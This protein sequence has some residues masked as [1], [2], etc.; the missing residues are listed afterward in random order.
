MSYNFQLDLMRI[1]IRKGI[2]MIIWVDH[3]SPIEKSSLICNVFGE[4]QV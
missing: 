4:F 3:F 2:L 1:E